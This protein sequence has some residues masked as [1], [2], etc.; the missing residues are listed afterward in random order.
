MENRDLAINV[1]S[2]CLQN[3]IETVGYRL[4]F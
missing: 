3:E 2:F 1:A 4:R